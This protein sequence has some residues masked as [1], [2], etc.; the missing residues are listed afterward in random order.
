MKD[1]RQVLRT[2]LISEK[3]LAARAKFNDYVFEVHRDANKIDIKMAVEKLYHVK[4]EKVMTANNP[5]KQRR[6]GRYRPGFTP[7]WKKAIVKLAKD[8]K[9]SEFENL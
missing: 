8:Q 6:M 7:E 5:G 9:I 4:V 3:S 1:P 2:L